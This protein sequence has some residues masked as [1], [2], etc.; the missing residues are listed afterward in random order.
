VVLVGD[1]VVVEEEDGEAGRFIVTSAVV[2]VEK[3]G[4]NK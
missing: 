2:D 1:V 4:S 3:E